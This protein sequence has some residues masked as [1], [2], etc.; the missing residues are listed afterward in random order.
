MD[1]SKP[2]PYLSS[3][4][5]CQQGVAIHTQNADS[6]IRLCGGIVNKIFNCMININAIKQNLKQTR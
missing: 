3:R 1:S 2:T 4:A 5:L 6:R